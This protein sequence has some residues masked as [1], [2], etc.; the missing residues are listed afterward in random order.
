MENL[1]LIADAET[2]NKQQWVKDCVDLYNRV[3][4]EGWYDNFKKFSWATKDVIM[5]SENSIYCNFVEEI[6]LC[7]LDGG[8]VDSKIQNMLDRDCKNNHQA[9]FEMCFVISFINCYCEDEESNFFQKWE[10]KLYADFNYIIKYIEFDEL[11]AL[12]RVRYMME[13]NEEIA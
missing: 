6:L 5:I 8:D 11:E 7:I 13:L 3:Y 10:E 1:K 4:R 9:Y 2:A 12:M